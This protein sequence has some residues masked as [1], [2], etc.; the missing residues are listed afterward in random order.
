MRKNYNQ[1]FKAKM[2][3]EVLRENKMLS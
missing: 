2:V 3:R 1:E